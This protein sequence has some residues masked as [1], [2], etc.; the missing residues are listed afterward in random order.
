MEAVHRQEETIAILIS[1]LQEIVD[2]G[3]GFQLD[4]AVVNTDAVVHV[5]HKIALL[6]VPQGS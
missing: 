3:A 5:D 1:H 4:Q 2:T 6:E